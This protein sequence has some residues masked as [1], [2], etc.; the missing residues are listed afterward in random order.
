M[1][2]TIVLLP[3]LLCDAAVWQ[4]VRPAL[5][6]LAPVRIGDFSEGSSMAG[7]ARAVLEASRGR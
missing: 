5:E 2:P 6:A 4:G 7:W 3:G 1:T